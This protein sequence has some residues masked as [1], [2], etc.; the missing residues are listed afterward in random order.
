MLLR[1]DVI[2]EGGAITTECLS[3]GEKEILF[4]VIVRVIVSNILILHAII[5]I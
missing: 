4:R 5:R 2:V 3:E 1:E